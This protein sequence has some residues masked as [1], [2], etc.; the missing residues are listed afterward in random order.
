MVDICDIGYCHVVR[1]VATHRLCIATLL[2]GCLR[3]VYLLPRLSYP[4]AR[5]NVVVMQQIPIHHSLAW[6]LL[7]LI[8]NVKEHIAKYLL[9]GNVKLL[10]Y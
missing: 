10:K 8:G 1:L 9:E 5:L 2:L 3:K 7:H 4:L 6:S